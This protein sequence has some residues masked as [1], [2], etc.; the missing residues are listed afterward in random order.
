MGY[1]QQVKT[2]RYGRTQRQLANE[3]RRMKKHG[4]I[5]PV[6]P[7][8]WFAVLESDDLKSLAVRSIDILGTKT[9]SK[10]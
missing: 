5:P 10:T 9:K 7:N 6:Y 4:D 2:D 1:S 8:G 3:V